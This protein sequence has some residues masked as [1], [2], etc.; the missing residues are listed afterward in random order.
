[1]LVSNFGKEFLY[2]RSIVA[3]ITISPSW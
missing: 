3:C 2:W 1:L